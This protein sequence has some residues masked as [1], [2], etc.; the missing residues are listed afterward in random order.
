MHSGGGAG[1]YLWPLHLV[2]WG[3]LCLVQEAS[4]E[5]EDEEDRAP[6]G[7]AGKRRDSASVTLAMVERWKQA[8]KVRSGVGWAADPA[9]APA[10]LLSFIY[11]GQCRWEEPFSEPVQHERI[12]QFSL[13][14]RRAQDC[15]LSFIQ[16]LGPLPSP[17]LSVFLQGSLKSTVGKT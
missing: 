3:P 13:H 14:A 4:E 11:L 1:A 5:E 10:P 6:R 2:Q 7:P 12:S 8:A 15:I 16:R 17:F 9:P